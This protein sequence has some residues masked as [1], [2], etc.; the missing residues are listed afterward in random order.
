MQCKRCGEELPQN[1]RF[2]PAC[3]EP[4]DSGIPAPKKLEEPLNP[5]AAGA[6]PLV[7]V[8]PPPRAT[9]LTPRIPKP[10]V[11]PANKRPSR[12]AETSRYEIPFELEPV[13]P[14]HRGSEKVARTR[15]ESVA[16]AEEQRPETVADPLAETQPMT[17]ELHEEPVE[18]NEPV[19]GPAE[20]GVPAEKDAP[21]EKVDGQD[22]P[23][24]S[25]VPTESL[26]DESS[27]VVTGDSAVVDEPAISA[28]PDLADVEEDSASEP[29]AAEVP[30]EP[31][32]SSAALDEADEASDF[33]DASAGPVEPGLDD[34]PADETAPMPPAPEPSTPS[35]KP[36]LEPAPACENP[37]AAVAER[38]RSGADGARA[39]ISQITP[40]RGA[41]VAVCAVV[42]VALVAFLVSISASWF[43]P[44]ANR[45]FETPEFEQPS[46]GSIPPLQQ[47]E[48]EEEPEETPTDGPEVRTALDE[49]SWEELSQ[50]SA[51]IA[52]APNDEEGLAIAKQYNLC[53]ATGAID[54]T[55]TKELALSNGT[56]VQVMVAGFRHDT[57]ADGSG[58]AGISFLTCTSVGDQPISNGDAVAW[59]GSS[60][61]S[62]LN[63]TLLGQLPEKLSELVVPVTKKTNVPLGSGGGTQTTDDSLWLLAYSEL[64][65]NASYGSY[66]LEGEQ[67]QVFFDRGVSWSTAVASLP[68]TESSSWWM[69]TPS[70]TDARWYTTVSPESNSLLYG[71][72]PA[73]ALGVIA[74]FCL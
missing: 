28:E 41:V 71:R 16:A 20:K 62:W 11:P 21:S 34:L 13:V 12:W 64:V 27:D 44:F 5:L 46:D 53:G 47:E 50:I 8:A 43:S 1:A 72:N 63:G 6:V 49:Y 48:P 32:A 69:R 51:L 40:A 56:T 55:N 3:G 67:Y 65:G 17:P 22:V 15:R 58:V 24:A 54:P 74:G 10:Y 4:V 2:C 73:N 19:V 7:P 61:R 35:S 39:A 36:A 9:R 25:D 31:A 45:D 38:L 52:A 59:E 37:A 42:A 68:V 29:A 70:P 33:A 66:Q 60:M 14:E 30:A 18:K 23:A 57:K 26:A